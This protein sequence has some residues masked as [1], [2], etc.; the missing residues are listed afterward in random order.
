QRLR[1]SVPGRR[2]R[3]EAGEVLFGTVDTFLIWRL[4]GGRVHV[5]DVSNASRTLVF[6]IHTL[7]WDDELLKLLGIPRRMLPAVRASSEVYGECEE[8]LLGGRIP[9]AAAGGHPQAATS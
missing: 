4:T 5:T 2:G 8:S 7:D 3:A 6:N 9:I 1:G